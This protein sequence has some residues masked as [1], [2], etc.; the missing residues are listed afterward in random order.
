M[1]MLAG[2]LVLISRSPKKVG[3]AGPPDDPYNEPPIKRSLPATTD[4]TNKK[5]L[6]HAASPKGHIPDD[7][8]SSN[9]VVSSQKLWENSI[10]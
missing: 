6:I 8:V 3:F 5:E 7:L 9:L 1:G 4:D 2:C 10:A